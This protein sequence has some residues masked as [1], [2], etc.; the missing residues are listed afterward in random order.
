MRINW[1]FNFFSS[2]GRESN[3]EFL[4]LEIPSLFSSSHVDTNCCTEFLSTDGG[5]LITDSRTSNIPAKKSRYISPP[6]TKTQKRTTAVILAIVRRRSLDFFSSRYEILI[7][8]RSAMF[9]L[10]T[11]YKNVGERD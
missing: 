5:V 11:T 6:I 10:Y 9:P 7:F 2:S 1:S 4:N 3:W 8:F